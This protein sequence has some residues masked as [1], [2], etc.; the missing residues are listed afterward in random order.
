[1][2]RA[3]LLRTLCLLAPAGVVIAVFVA[4]MNHETAERRV[5]WRQQI[6]A[7]VRGFAQAY[8]ACFVGITAFIA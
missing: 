8:C 2:K 1:M 7:E 6:F 4:M 3:S 5:P